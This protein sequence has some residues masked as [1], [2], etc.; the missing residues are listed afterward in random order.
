MAGSGWTTEIRPEGRRL[1]DRLM[2]SAGALEFF[3]AN[4]MYYGIPYLCRSWPCG[5]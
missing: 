1:E 4:I 5:G 3:V 2:G